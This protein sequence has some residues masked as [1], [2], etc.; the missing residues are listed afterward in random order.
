MGNER[1]GIIKRVLKLTVFIFL[2]LAVV[3]LSAASVGIMLELT[4]GEFEQGNENTEQNGASEAE[5]RNGD[6]TEPEEEAD[7]RLKHHEFNRRSPGTSHE[8]VS[9]VG[10]VENK[11]NDTASYTEIR[12]R[13][14]DE[15][16]FTGELERTG[17]ENLEP[18]DSWEFEVTYP[19][20]GEPA[21]KLTDYDIRVTD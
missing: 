13:F 21:S 3:G 2:T 9:V 19:R 16:G 15:D 4:G 20:I 8:S 17:R 11:G 7:V 10:E 14:Q 5:D 6:T 18:G 1:D 12:I